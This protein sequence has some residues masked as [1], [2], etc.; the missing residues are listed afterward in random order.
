MSEIVQD[1]QGTYRWVHEFNLLT[2][3]TVLVTL[4][5]VLSGVAVVLFAL[6]GIMDL[7]EGYTSAEDVLERLRFDGI[8]LLVIVVLTLVGYV[9][10]A[11]MQGGKYCVVFTMDEEGIEHKQ[12]PKQYKKDQVVGALNVLAGLAGGNPTQAG[13]G[14]LSASRD[15]SYS[16]FSAVRSIKGSR[17]LRVIK[18][19]EPLMKNQVY[20][21]PQDYD[22]VFGY[23]RDHCPNATNVKG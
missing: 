9:A 4:L 18:V 12:L 13:I 6:F 2:N 8:I 7:A 23:I 15:S 5:K 22:F 1:E 20:V 10:Y 19:N 21:E 11:V 3:P 14:F 17:M 16:T